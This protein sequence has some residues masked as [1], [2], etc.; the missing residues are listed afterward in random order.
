M[1]VVLYLLQSSFFIHLELAGVVPN[2]LIILT[3]TAGIVSGSREGCIIGFFCG[4]LMDLTG[5]GI[6]G[7]Y[8]L[9]YLIAGYLAGIVNRFFYKEDITFPILLVAGTDFFYGLYMYFFGFLT[10]GRMEFGFYLLHIILP[11][12]V[13]T[14]ILALILYRP[15]MHIVQRQSSKGS[16]ERIA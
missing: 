9:G 14:V 15:V 4:L 10:R 2:L 11:E 5:G 7:M 3:A 1:I 12:V 8:A 16:E 6:V 13:Y